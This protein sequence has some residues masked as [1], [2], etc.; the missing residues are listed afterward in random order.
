MCSALISVTA[1]AH[2][3]K[4][5]RRAGAPSFNG[6]D[7]DA[8]Q[9]VTFTRDIAPIIFRSCAPCHRPGESAPFSLL[10]YTDAK[11][12]AHQI[13][14]VTERRIMPPWLPAPDDPKFADDLRLS[15]GEIA[16]IQAWAEQGA[17][18][19]DPSAVPPKP[20]FVEG[21]QLGKPDVIVRATQ[22][23]ALPPGGSDTYWNFVF[24]APVDRT[25]WLKAI[26][27]RPGDKRLVHHA[28][29]LVDRGQ[30]ARL[31][32]RQQGSGFGGMEL[33]I[34]SEVFDPDSHF[35]FW[36]PGSAPYVEP[37][38]MAIRLDKNTDLILNT[39]LQ[40]SGKPEVLQP[41]L[42]L[43]FTDKPATLHPILLQ[44]END[45]Q[46]DIPPG[47][48][49]F[50]VT[51]DFTLPVDVELLAIYP[52]AHYL[53]KD[54]QG[55]ATLPDGT[56][57]TLIHIARW[58]LNWQA[59][60]R[61][62]TPMPLPK[63][64]TISM[65]FTYDNS[66]ENIRNPNHPPQRVVAG[67][68]ASDEM[69]HLWLQV[70]PKGPANLSS[71]QARSAIQENGI[72]ESGTA[73]DPRALIQEAM[74]RHNL[75]KNPNDFEAHY[76]LAAL[77]QGRGELAESTAH[78]A[79]AV[80]IRPEDATANNALG[81]A[82]LAAGRPDQSIPYLSAALTARPNYF[83][84]HYNLGNA[85]ASQGDFS[86][87][88]VHF[89]AAVSL[90][91]EDANAEANLGSAFAETGN[92]KEARL[93]Y[94]RALKLNPNHQLARENLQQLEQDKTSDAPN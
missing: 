15:A 16:L 86:G 57:R 35:L 72:P 62:A 27:I 20:Q 24:R 46:L 75:E 54:L 56:K 91:P 92:L 48:T 93:H 59:V 53:G 9:Q 32:E 13:A 85:L 69:A 3:G 25:R 94:E 68:R 73:V 14:A 40:P 7:S 31:Q 55:I 33:I 44:M 76:N 63:G 8:S 58:D 6:S 81:A 52:H 87:A 39:H 19:G 89:R 71:G 23:F 77:L 83:D 66:A 4:A 78:F 84:A 64:T 70:L 10:S 43:Y 60:Y 80:R 42:G 34:E 36:K 18:E 41:S 49:N 11:S 88:L 79:Q 90:N 61:Y 74:A 5:A 1:A 65:R 12:H 51:D 67:N 38:G 21:W 26:E 29:V 47:E 45:R 30:T 28:N 17:P 50:L 37:D 2:Y 22:A 82:L